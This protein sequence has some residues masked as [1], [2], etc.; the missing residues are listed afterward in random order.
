MYYSKQPFPLVYSTVL[1]SIALPQV[2]CILVLHYTFNSHMYHIATVTDVAIIHEGV[3]YSHL[4]EI[5]YKYSYSN[6]T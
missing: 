2:V 6:G 5:Q 1:P 3:Q 4:H